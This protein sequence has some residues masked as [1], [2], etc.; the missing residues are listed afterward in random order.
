MIPFFILSTLAIKS[1]STVLC[2]F[3]TLFFALISDSL[4][5]KPFSRFFCGIFCYVCYTRITATNETMR[6]GA[7]VLFTHCT[8]TAFGLNI[9]TAFVDLTLAC[10]CIALF[11]CTGSLASSLAFFHCRSK[12]SL[13]TFYEN[14]S[15]MNTLVRMLKFLFTPALGEQGLLAATFVV[16]SRP[17]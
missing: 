15:I 13:V 5:V 4:F 1:L 6:V 7:S 8:F 17:R 10:L 9:I 2:S 12:S 11:C 16:F 14:F 3:D